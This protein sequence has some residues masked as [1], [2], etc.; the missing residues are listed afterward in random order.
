MQPSEYLAKAANA[1]RQKRYD[2]AL[3][4]YKDAI[5]TYPQFL[6]SYYAYAKFLGRLGK[7]KEVLQILVA[8][9]KQ[10]PK[11]ANTHYEIGLF[12]TQ[13]KNFRAAL[14]ALNH[15][16]FLRPDFAQAFNAKGGL[17]YKMQ[18]FD[19]AKEAFEKALEVKPDYFETYINLGA[20]YNRLK[21]YDKAKTALELAIEKLPQNAGAYTNLGNVYNNTKE[22]EKA[23][24]YHLL[25]IERDPKNALAYAN[26]GVAQKN[27]AQMQSAITNFQKAIELSPHFI[28]A[29]F[30]LATALLSVGAF[31]TG[32]KAYEW[33]FAKEQMKGFIATHKDIFSKP[34]LT[35]NTNAYNKTL[36]IHSE[37]GFGDSIMF[38]RFIKQIR[39]TFGCKIIFKARDEL[40]TLFQN[41]FD[42][43]VVPRS[44][45]T[46]PFDLHLPIMSAAFLLGVSSQKDFYVKSYL[47]APENKFT[48]Q[49]G[50]KNIGIC[51]SASTSGESYES[52][53]FD[54]AFFKPLLN[55]DDFVLHSLAVDD[56]DNAAKLKGVL[57]HS[58]SIND[59]ADTASLVKALDL[60]ITCDTSVA[61][62][63]G[64]LGVRTWVVLQKVP[65]WRWGLDGSTSYLY[66]SVQ[67]FRQQKRG[68]W[69]SAFNEVYKALGLFR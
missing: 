68:D 25:A 30:D 55:R 27:L 52:K 17:L 7:N 43:T 11:E 20:T 23:K 16:I 12:H 34:M 36:L 60:V 22:Y 6:G 39:Q 3:Q 41:S 38:A 31:E 64:A 49:K 4:C 54:S 44:E 8:A 2:V 58:A 19:A 26:L 57:D 51:W 32:F 21:L 63:C 14:Q 61:H 56:A 66:P 13:T 47:K 46:P 10:N 35:K 69:Q 48:L 53:V 40:V 28:N 42:C 9:L 33:R 15:A 18:R 24:Q 59:F 65:D 62:L 45:K 37:Q 50:K 67:L 1:L 29:R 5:R